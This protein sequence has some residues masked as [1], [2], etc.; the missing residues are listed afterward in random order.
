METPLH[1]GAD[2]LLLVDEGRATMLSWVAQH[3]AV[4]AAKRL[5]LI[6]VA[7]WLATGCGAPNEPLPEQEPT[8]IV[9]PGDGGTGESARQ[10]CQSENNSLLR[11]ATTTRADSDAEI[12]PGRPTERECGGPPED[13]SEDQM[14]S[15]SPAPMPVQP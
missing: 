8:P 3:T 4:A 15:A 12:S 2:E 9:E 11:D 10:P 6:C 5:L 13:L 1:D 7:A 14:R